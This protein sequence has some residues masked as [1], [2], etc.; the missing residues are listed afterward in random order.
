MMVFA[1]WII[2]V[3]INGQQKEAK[4]GVSISLIAISLLSWAIVYVFSNGTT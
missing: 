1:L 3:K 2:W 4:V